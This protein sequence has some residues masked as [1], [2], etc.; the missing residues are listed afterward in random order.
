MATVKTVVTIEATFPELLG[1]AAHQQA[2]GLGNSRR[3]AMKNAVDDLM[4][5][6]KLRRKRFTLLNCTVSIAK[7]RIVPDEK[8]K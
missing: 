5:Q 1:S 8:E 3:V 4:R 7:I 6:P 2:R